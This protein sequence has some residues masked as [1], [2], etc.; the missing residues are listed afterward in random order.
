MG[1]HVEKSKDAELGKLHT[2][3][4]M[5][6]AEAVGTPKIK[7]LKELRALNA[8]RMAA[9]VDTPK[10]KELKSCEPWCKCRSSRHPRVRHF[11]SPRH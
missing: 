11:V 6:A 10:T 7:E 4:P 2:Q 9:A 8:T 3:N 5:P 1:V